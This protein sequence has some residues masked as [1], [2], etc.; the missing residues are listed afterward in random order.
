MSDCVFPENMALILSYCYRQNK[1]MDFT[2][3][4]LSWHQSLNGQPFAVKDL[5]V[6]PYTGWLSLSLLFKIIIYTKLGKVE[7]YF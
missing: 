5:W 4:S 7:S 6:N 2:T 1:G 3:A